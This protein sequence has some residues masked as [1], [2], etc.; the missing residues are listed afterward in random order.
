MYAKDYLL[1]D[2]QAKKGGGHHIARSRL[3]NL[4]ILTDHL[5][6]MGDLTPP[7]TFSVNPKAH[8]NLAPPPPL[9]SLPLAGTRAAK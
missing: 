5:H 1:E 9:L 2:V 3:M 4:I 6:F 8:K 7:F